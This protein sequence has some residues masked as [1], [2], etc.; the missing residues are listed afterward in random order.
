MRRSLALGGGIGREL[1]PARGC[2]SQ[3]SLVVVLFLL[4]VSFHLSP[5]LR[6]EEVLREV[7]SQFQEIHP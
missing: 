5:S 7:T 2:L 3:R 6:S 4:M 1:M